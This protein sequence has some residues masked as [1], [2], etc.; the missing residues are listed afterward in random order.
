MLAFQVGISVVWRVHGVVD[1]KLLV[2]GTA[3][4][5]TRSLLDHYSMFVF[6]VVPEQPASRFHVAFRMNRTIHFIAQTP[7]PAQIQKC[8]QADYHHL[9]KEEA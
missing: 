9:E 7:H 1:L 3:N 4:S 8:G 6:F 5:I 2:E